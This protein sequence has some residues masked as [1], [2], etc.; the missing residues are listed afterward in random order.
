MTPVPSRKSHHQKLLVVQGRDGLVALCGGV[1]IN[2]DRVYD[3]PPP[4]WLLP[5]VIAR[6]IGWTDSSGGSGPEGS[7]NPLHDVHARLTGPDRAAAAA[8]LPPPLVG[9]LR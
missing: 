6:T 4:P 5:V 1:D 9:A 2:A 7:G 3:L 8:C